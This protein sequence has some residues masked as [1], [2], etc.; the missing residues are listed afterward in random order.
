MEAQGSSTSTLS[1]GHRH[2]GLCCYT[3]IAACKP[4]VSH[5][6]VDVHQHQRTCLP[7]YMHACTHT[8]ILTLPTHLHGCMIT[9]SHTCMRACMY[10]LM[11][12]SATL[13][14]MRIHKYL[15]TCTGQIVRPRKPM[16]PCYKPLGIIITVQNS[17]A[18]KRI[19]ATVFSKKS[20]H[21]HTHTNAHVAK[22]KRVCLVDAHLLTPP[23]LLSLNKH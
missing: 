2:R 13:Q 19:F 18:T 10:Y 14:Y 22:H 4:V 15:H 20:W 9:N 3:I 11:F 6:Y 12:C 17:W 21:T 7:K 8:H 23:V 1:T 16:F 5:A